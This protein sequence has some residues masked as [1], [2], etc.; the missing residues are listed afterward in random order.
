MPVINDYK[1]YPAKISGVPRR[2]NIIFQFPDHV[3]PIVEDADPLGPMYV[4]IDPL[5]TS[6]VEWTSALFM[7]TKDGDRYYISPH[8]M[9][10]WDDETGRPYITINGRRHGALRTHRL[11]MLSDL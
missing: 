6:E 4:E 1:I 10:A 11:K 9:H 3:E 7:F 2:L 5:L 8:E